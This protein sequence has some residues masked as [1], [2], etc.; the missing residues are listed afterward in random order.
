MTPF[1]CGN[2]YYSKNLKEGEKAVISDEPL[3]IYMYQQS[4]IEL[5]NKEN[6]ESF[7]YIPDDDY[8]D[9]VKRQTDF[10]AP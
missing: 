8:L 3:F 10:R 1:I 4:S 5:I 7:I 9:Y 6:G 2:Y